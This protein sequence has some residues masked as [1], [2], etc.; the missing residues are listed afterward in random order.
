[1]NA[2]AKELLA[3]GRAAYDTGGGDMLAAIA[4]M[5]AAPPKARKRRD[6]DETKLPF[7]PREL[8]QLMLKRIPHLVLCEPVEGRLFGYLGK[9]LQ[10][11]NGL[12]RDDMDRLVSWLEA[13]ALSYWASQPTFEHV[14]QH[15][16]KWVTTAREWDKRGRQQLRKG[17]SNVGT[18]AGGDDVGGM[19]R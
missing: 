14:C 6:Y 17:G 1:M 13:G 9:R 18:E 8:H 2:R 11:I 5:L 10:M 16:G 4:V 12:E 15:I 3:L 7:G 19:F